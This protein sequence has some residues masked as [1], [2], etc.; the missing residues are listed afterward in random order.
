VRRGSA[1]ITFLGHV[2][3]RAR[4]ISCLHCN[5]AGL[6]T[7]GSVLPKRDVCLPWRSRALTLTAYQRSGGEF[8]TSP[9]QSSTASIFRFFMHI[10]S[11]D[12]LAL[13]IFNPAFLGVRGS[14]RVTDC[15]SSRGKIDR[16][17]PAELQRRSSQKR[18]F[19]RSGAKAESRRT[20]R[21]HEWRI[22]AHDR[23]PCSKKST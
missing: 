11:Y 5:K 3:T 10:L 18:R 13:F 23:V 19:S 22:P 15:R 12:I 1:S 6:L 21:S 7:S 8:T 2:E 4:D 16:P 20:I 14:R 17:G 9:L